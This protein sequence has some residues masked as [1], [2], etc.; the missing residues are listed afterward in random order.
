M[1][2]DNSHFALTDAQLHALNSYFLDRNI[3]HAAAGEDAPSGVSVEFFFSSLDRFIEARFN[4]DV[5]PFV[6]ED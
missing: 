2:L 4:G 5:N 3:K 6:V 1:A